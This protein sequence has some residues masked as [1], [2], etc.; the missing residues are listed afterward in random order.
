MTDFFSR[1]WR[2]IK[3]PPAVPSD[4]K[5]SREQIRR[6]RRLV[7]AA[8]G[9]ILGSGT[10][11]GIYS[12]ADT[13]PQRADHELQAGVRMMGSGRYRTAVACFDRA[14]RIRPQLAEAYLNRGLAHRDLEE[15]Q[16]ALEDFDQA[17]DLDPAMAR[18]CDERGRIYRDRG[19]ARRAM[20]EFSKSIEIAP[21][22]DEYYQRGEMYE[23]MGE[24]QKAIDD[25]TEAVAEMRD[26]PYVYRARALAR[27]NLGDDQGAAADRTLALEA[28]NR[29]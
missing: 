18:A 1:W 7:G 3:P 27:Q 12:Y 4:R 21:S 9:V 22:V 24:H 6:R 2:A 29:H 28:E 10:A 8:T 15:T 26:A 16:A 23:S 19:D 25:Y 20:Q 5:V 13:A 14:L 11:W 17:F